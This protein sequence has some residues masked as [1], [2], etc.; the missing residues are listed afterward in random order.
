MGGGWGDYWL[1]RNNKIVTFRKVTL[2]TNKNNN[3]KRLYL[4]RASDCKGYP[5]KSQCAG[6]APEKR[7]AV[8]IY[9]EEYERVIARIKSSAYYR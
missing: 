4:T 7:I 5:Y 8:T 1:C 2:E 6:K 3:R 9:K